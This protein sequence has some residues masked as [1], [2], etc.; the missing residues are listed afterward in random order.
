[1]GQRFFEDSIGSL[2]H[3]AGI[4]SLSASR[5]TIGGQ[6]EYFTS[7][8]YTISALSAS[9]KY[10]LFLVKSGGI[11]SLVPST[12]AITVGPTGY[13]LFKFIRSFTT[14]ASS[15]FG[16]FAAAISDPNPVGTV[17]HSMLTLAQFQN[18]Y[19]TTWVLADGS[20]VADS[21]YQLVTGNSTVPDARGIFIRGAGTHGTLLKR[22]GGAISGTLGQLQQD[23]ANSLQEVAYGSGGD[24]SSS[25]TIP[26]DGTY[27]SR[28]RTGD[29]TGFG[30]RLRKKGV[31][32][33]PANIAL[34][35]FIK[36]NME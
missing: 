22:A 8:S 35:V 5:I 12:N 11:L 4:I 7:L 25:G 17:I 34:N 15:T 32:T 1:M 14:N 2:S 19:G 18:L 3:N 20:S 9:T 30:H 33:A 24:G 10:N 29:G 23:D 28:A 13:T 6:Q 31:E 16:S 21:M 27:S 36:I 26:E